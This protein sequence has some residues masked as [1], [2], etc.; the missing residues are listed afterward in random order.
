MAAKGELNEESVLVDFFVEAR[1]QCVQ[2]LDCGANDVFAEFAVEKCVHLGNVGAAS[3]DATA[4]FTVNWGNLWDDG[5]SGW[6]IRFAPVDRGLRG[7]R[8]WRPCAGPVGP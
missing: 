4:A 5:G 7:W 6:M 1:L 8:G 2:D 3:E